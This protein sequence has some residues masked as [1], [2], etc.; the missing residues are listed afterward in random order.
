LRTSI[1]P[2]AALWIPVLLTFGLRAIAL[3]HAWSIPA[4]FIN[5][6]GDADI[7][8]LHRIDPVTA[9]TRKVP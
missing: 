1:S 5:R 2:V 9:R 8:Q 4:A 3:R 7:D 6:D